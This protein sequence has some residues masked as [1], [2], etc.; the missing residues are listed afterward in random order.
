L[1]METV[2]PSNLVTLLTYVVM[3]LGAMGLA[4]LFWFAEGRA[5]AGNTGE[6]AE[7]GLA[8]KAPDGSVSINGIPVTLKAQARKGSMDILTY[9]PCSVCISFKVQNPLGAKLTIDREGFDST[10]VA[11]FR[12]PKLPDA[13]EWLTD[14][15]FKVRA[16][17]ADC[18]AGDMAALDG[19]RCIVEDGGDIR[20]VKL[21]GHE[22]EFLITSGDPSLADDL[23]RQK[24]RLNA[25]AALA[26]RFR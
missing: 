14:A 17:P 16:K 8:E 1:P 20:R 26:A 24:A 21:S 22:M 9:D 4:W 19:L 10:S 2:A 23:E 6:L 25:C 5:A 12:L 3:L 15:G 13:P 7:R 11:M 18:F